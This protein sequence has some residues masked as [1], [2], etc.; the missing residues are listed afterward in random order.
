M[1]HLHAIFFVCP[2][3]AVEGARDRSFSLSVASHR[4]VLCLAVPVVHTHLYPA[5]ASGKGAS[6]APMQ[7]FFPHPFCCFPADSRGDG[8]LN[9]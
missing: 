8:A 9:G 3:T 1:V 6:D 7:T 4:I 5:A 2:S